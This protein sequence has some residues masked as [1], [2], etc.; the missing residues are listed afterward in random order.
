[1]VPQGAV[2]GAI[3]DASQVNLPPHVHI[4]VL[5]AEGAYH[6]PLK[7]FP[8]LDD[9]QPPVIKGLYLVDN[10]NHVV[11]A[12]ETR[13]P[14]LQRVKL[15]TYELVVDA[16]DEMPP[17]TIGQPVHRLEVFVEIGHRD[18]SPITRR[19]AS[20]HLD[21]LPEKDFLS[22]VQTIYKINPI[23]RHDG[24]PI[25][26]QVHTARPRKFLFRFPLE[27]AMLPLMTE[28]GINVVAYDYA[29]NQDTC[30]MTLL[31]E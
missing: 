5:D 16:L 13:E 25:T 7:F 3:Y 21:R 23:L 20:V 30:R 8:S 17:S 2:L 27:E 18:A 22:G 1:M 11:A 19:I 15:G 6:D 24:T 4:N 31:L 12:E 10:R 29:G 28:V 14:R 26:N 9:P